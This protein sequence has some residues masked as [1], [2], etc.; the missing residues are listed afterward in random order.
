MIK[1]NQHLLNQFHVVLDALIIAGAWAL[2]WYLMIG[3]RIFPA[4]YG[5]LPPRIYFSA[6]I[7]IIPVYLILYWAFGL[8]QPKRTRTKRTEFF[9]ICKANTIGLMLFTSV[10]YLLR[11]SGYFAHFSTRMIAV[12]Y[13]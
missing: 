9:N 1:N 11:R 13:L 5:V 4:G 8:Y 3:S 6:L 2:A 12:F 10:L 7:P